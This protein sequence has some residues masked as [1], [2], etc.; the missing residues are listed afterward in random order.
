MPSVL[1][2]NLFQVSGQQHHNPSAS[3]AGLYKSTSGRVYIGNL[4]FFS[5][6]DILAEAGEAHHP[7]LLMK[8]DRLSTTY[9]SGAQSSI[10]LFHKSRIYVYGNANNL[11]TNIN[12]AMQTWDG[13]ALKNLRWALFCDLIVYYWRKVGVI[14][15]KERR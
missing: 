1:E 12:N 13:Q 14:L 9:D 2:L 3:E 8:E 4:F 7:T 5:S 11:E 6:A 15:P 10:L